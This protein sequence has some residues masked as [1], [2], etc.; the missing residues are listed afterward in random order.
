MTRITKIS[1]S[2]QLF[3]VMYIYIYIYSQKKSSFIMRIEKSIDD[4]STLKYFDFKLLNNPMP[5]D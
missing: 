1:I 5:Y 3:F 4:F 2:V